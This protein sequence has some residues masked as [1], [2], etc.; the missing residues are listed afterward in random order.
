MEMYDIAIVGTGPAGLS[1][2]ITATIRNKKIILIGSKKLS[3]KVEKA[4]EILNY[5]GLPK[6]SGNELKDAYLKHLNSL[7]IEI[8]EDK[9]NAVYAMGDFFSIM[10]N[11]TSYQAKTVILATGVDFG[12]P[13]KGEKEYLGSGVSYC[14]TCDAFAYRGKNVAVIGYEALAQK[15]AEFL[16]E[17]TNKV[18]YLP[19]HKE[20]VNLSKEIEIVNDIPDEIVGDF[21]VNTL[22]TKS[23]EIKVDG[24]FIFRESVTPSQL[25]GG[26]KMQDNHIDVNMQM[27]T[28]IEGLF[29]CGDVVGTPYQYIKAAGQGNVAALSAVNYLGKIKK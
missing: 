16:K 15:E 24:V 26:L 11:G 9:I 18:Y 5:P 19:I 8:T 25:V 17:M 21:K 20:E 2:A 23:G 7:S 13:I 12:K 27:E 1:A 6:V 4:H 3:N 22:K 14:A 28:N 29:A 10:G